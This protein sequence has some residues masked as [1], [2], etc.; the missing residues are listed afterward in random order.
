MISDINQQRH[1][2]SCIA[3]LVS[4]A[5]ICRDVLLHRHTPRTP[6]DKFS[7][8]LKKEMSIVGEGC[9][10]SGKNV[11]IKQCCIGSNCTIGQMAKLNNCIVMDGVKI[12][13][14]YVSLFLFCLSFHCFSELFINSFIYF[15]WWCSLFLQLHDPEF[16]YL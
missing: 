9:D 3:I 8:Y 15:L 6:W 11:T 5:S 4:C 16:N 10:V 12:G 2:R 14:K 1:T 7:N 13:E